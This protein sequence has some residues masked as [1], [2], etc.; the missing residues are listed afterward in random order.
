MKIRNADPSGATEF[1]NPEAV[2]RS[3]NELENFTAYAVIDASHFCI[4]DNGTLFSLAGQDGISF[5]KNIL[6]NC[7]YGYQFQRNENVFLEF[8]HRYAESDHFNLEE[9]LQ[10]ITV[11]FLC[12]YNMEI[13]GL[14]AKLNSTNPLDESIHVGSYMRT[15]NSDNIDASFD[16]YYRNPTA[17]KKTKPVVGNGNASSFKA[18]VE[19]KNWS[20]AI[21]SETVKTILG[22]ALETENCLVCF[23]FCESISNPN[24][25]HEPLLNLCNEKKI[26]PYKIGKDKDENLFTSFVTIPYF[27]GTSTELDFESNEAELICFVIE[28]AHLRK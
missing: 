5:L 19:C 14:L 22:Y 20:R 6:R 26:I 15:P 1:P 21:P 2:S 18:V 11:P 9:F 23:I 8:T 27:N 10:N 4:N 3:G 16:I 12:P 7:F 28:L 24:E 13:P 17:A 25:V